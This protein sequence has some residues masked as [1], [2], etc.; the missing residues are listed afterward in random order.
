MFLL[1]Y[2]WNVAQLIREN[3]A[4]PFP[5]RELRKNPTANEVKENYSDLEKTALLFRLKKKS[6]LDL[7][8]TALFNHL[9]EGK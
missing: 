9:S 2:R 7:E 5:C 3:K 4:L 8:K 1:R 6:K